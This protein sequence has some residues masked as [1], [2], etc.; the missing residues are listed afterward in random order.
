[1]GTNKSVDGT[2]VVGE[3]K[4]LAAIG[5]A[6]ANNV[7]VLEEEDTDATFAD[8][9]LPS[10]AIDIND[11]DSFAGMV[12]VDVKNPLPDADKVSELDPDKVKSS[13]DKNEVRVSIDE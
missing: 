3:E 11:G 8:D 9:E 4:L 2:N 7:E 13:S 12:V 1:M 10:L 6:A 5:V